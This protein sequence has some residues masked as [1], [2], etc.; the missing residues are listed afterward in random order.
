MQ[1]IGDEMQE[2]TGAL[3]LSEARPQVLDLCMA[4]GGYSA[5]VLKHSPHAHI[6][7]ITLPGHLGGHR[8]LIAYGKKDPRVNVRFIDITMLAAEF[9][10]TEIHDDHP[11]K[12]NFLPDRVWAG[13]LFDLVF[14]D[15]QVLRTHAPHLASYREQREA[16]RLICSQL[17]LAMQRIRPGGTLIML[18]HKVEMWQ[19]MRLLNTFNNIAQISLFK[20]IA[21]H[22]KRGSFYLIAKDVQP[23]RSE[24]LA[25]IAKWKLA[26][27]EATFPGQTETGE[28]D[29]DISSLLEKFGERLIELGEPVWKIQRDALKEAPW[30]KNQPA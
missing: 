28:D 8:L 27:K 19:T 29:E 26:W 18:L 15:G 20:P 17:V 2:S 4:P 25:A 11:D 24:A 23:Y 12:A 21:G 13:E 1:R 6:S 3:S 14:C 10:I 5:S 7:G 16:G 22:A 9:D 30:F